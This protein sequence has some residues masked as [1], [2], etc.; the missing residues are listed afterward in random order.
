MITVVGE[1]VHAYSPA[2]YGPFN[3]RFE[4]GVWL[5]SQAKKLLHDLRKQAEEGT[6]FYAED[7]WELPKD[8]QE[9]EYAE[10]TEDDDA[11]TW[12]RVV[13]VTRP[14]DAE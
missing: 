12:W 1:S 14:E 6:V 4:A 11:V 7:K 5:H 9:P 2:V 3:T 10:L 8:R 13:E